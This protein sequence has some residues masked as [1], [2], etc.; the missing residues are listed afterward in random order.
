M[1]IRRPLEA[2]FEHSWSLMANWLSG[3]LL[4]AHFEHFWGL[5][6]KLL[7]GGLWRL[8][9]RISVGLLATAVIQRSILFVL[10]HLV[11]ID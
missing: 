2:Q 10:V 4:E 3:G 11:S 9:L 1:A 5:L 8:I 7:S 6:A